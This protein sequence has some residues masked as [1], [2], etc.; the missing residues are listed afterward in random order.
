MSGAE[1]AAHILP[2]VMT[3]DT[4]VPAYDVIVWYDFSA[5]NRHGADGILV[6]LSAIK[7]TVAGTNPLLEVYFFYL[8]FF[9]LQVPIPVRHL[10]L[11]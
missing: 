9:L 8:F 3:H 2:R 1:G 10:I 6:T 5:A 11:H 7:W 4:Y